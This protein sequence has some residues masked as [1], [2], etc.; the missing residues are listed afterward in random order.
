[1]AM[2][3]CKECG[4]AVSSKAAACPGCG[5]KPPADK[6]YALTAI[7]S[8]V[9][10]LVLVLII[11]GMSNPDPSR[12]APSSARDTAP[13]PA[14][15]EHDERSAFVMC[16]PF[17]E[18]RLTNPRSARYP[19]R[20]TSATRTGAQTYRIRAWVD[21]ENPMGGTIRN[22]FT[23]VIEYTGDGQWRLSDLSITPR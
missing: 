11:A 23:C 7:M 4:N 20:A 15:P 10:F 5:A 22:N 1:M 6:D 8:A 9:V 21:A 14:T 16:Q 3:K 19:T 2:V 17:V 13:A 12:S 18:Q